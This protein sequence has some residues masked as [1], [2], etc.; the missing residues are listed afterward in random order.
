MPAD[1]IW[2]GTS[3]YDDADL[4]GRAWHVQSLAAECPQVFVYFKHEGTGSGPRFAN[5]LLEHLGL[6]GESRG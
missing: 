1:M 4:A 3:G 5:V 2:V 6:K